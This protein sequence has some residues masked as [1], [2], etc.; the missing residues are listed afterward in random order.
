MSSSADPPPLVARP[1]RR[2]LRTVL[3]VIAVFVAGCLVGATT[4][5]IVIH[6]HHVEVMQHPERLPAMMLRVMRHDL[7]LSDEQANR[8]ERI[9]QTRHRAID[10][11]RAEVQP[12]FEHEFDLLEVEVGEQLDDAQREQWL[13]RIRSFRADCLPPLPKIPPMPA[14]SAS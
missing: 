8:I 6:R 14:A 2:I 7:N 1:P 13:Q 5:V 11:L 4:T 10:L 3:G 9:F 12:R